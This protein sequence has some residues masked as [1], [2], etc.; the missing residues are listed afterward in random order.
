MVSDERKD[1]PSVE[2]ETVKYTEVETT[3]EIGPEVKDWLTQLEQG[4]EIKLPQ[5]VTDDQGQILVSNVAP[6]QV[7]ITLPLTEAEMRRA[8]HLKLV[9]AARWL[10]E[11][12]NRLSQIMG[13]RLVY[14]FKS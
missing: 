13:G 4:E 5:P 6:Q 2:P 14:K 8:L 11:Q 12:M 10:G 9:Y 7:T 3:P 1:I